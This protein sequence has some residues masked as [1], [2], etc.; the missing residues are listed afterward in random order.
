MFQGF[1]VW[2]FVL[3][4]SVLAGCSLR[5]YAVNMVGDALVT[6]NSVYETDDDVELV[7]EAL[8]F[9]LKLV[10][11]LLE[12]SPKHRGLLLTAARGFVLYSYATVSD[13]AEVLEDVDLDL[14]RMAR[15][16]ARKLYLRGL[17][18]GL[19]G[20]EISYP[21]FGE[22]L[23]LNPEGAVVEVHNQKREQQD[24]PFLYWSAAALG[25]GISVSRDDAAML[26][27]LP[28]VDA[29]LDRALDLDESWDGGALHEFAIQLASS[30][31]GGTDYAALA[32]HYN[33]VTA[34][35]KHSRA[36]VY[37]SYAEA[38][39]LPQQN[40]PKFRALLEKALA[41]DPGVD[42]SKR[43]VNV[44]AQRRAR[45]LLEKIDDLIL[46]PEKVQ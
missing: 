16:R 43:L 6:G 28:E 30:K 5:K 17:A 23:F 2:I 39:W 14:A 41:L 44:L 18:Y 34:L 36:G 33:R 13:R 42:L 3:L 12:E 8:P 9:G 40:K 10:E 24:L 38:V 7:G 32:E 45:R 25:L 27:R 22:N 4:L 1:T 29:M 20:L 26:A 11:G 37:V 21:G 31:P 46:D 19:Q 35:S 15:L